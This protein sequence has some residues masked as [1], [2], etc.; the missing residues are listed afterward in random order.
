MLKWIKKYA[1]FGADALF[2]T[3]ADRFRS[4]FWLRHMFSVLGLHWKY[5][6][7]FLFLFLFK[8]S[9]TP[10]LNVVVLCTCFSL[11]K[12]SND[13]CID[14]RLWPPQKTTDE[15]AKH[16][17]Y[18]QKHGDVVSLSVLLLF[19]SQ[20]KFMG[21]Q[22]SLCIAQ[23]P[24]GSSRHVSTRSTCRARWDERVE[25]CCF[26]K[27]DTA[28]MRGFDRSNVTWRAKWNLGLY[29]FVFFCRLV[30]RSIRTGI[31]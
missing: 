19:L 6:V 9:R 20:V 17:F 8:C 26:D 11:C 16:T 25:P 15:R 7:H 22:R 23:I 24:L 2:E 10:H 21:L 4:R 28:K 31:L 5:G 18:C 30:R 3:D 29:Q 13:K 27:L 12:P 1:I 14:K